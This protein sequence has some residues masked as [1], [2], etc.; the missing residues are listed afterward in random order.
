MHT[1]TWLAW[2]ITAL[3]LSGLTNNPSYLI[4][5]NLAATL[6][7]LNCR[8]STPLTRAY[9]L[10]FFAGF[11]IWIG[12]IVFSVITIGGARGRT[13]LTHLPTRTL[14]PLLGGITLG[15]PITL[16]DIIWGA[17]R[18]LRIWTILIIFGTF[19]AL[20]DHYR[21]LRL[22][23]RSLFHAGLAVTIA[24][25]FVPQT[26][27]AISE[28]TEAQRVRG[29]RL[30]NPRTWITLVAPLLASSLEKSIQ[31]AEALDSRGYGRTH[32]T[33]L[34]I[35]REQLGTI[36]GL[37]LL[38]G[39]LFGWLYY[40]TAATLISLILLITGILTI[41]TTLRTLGRLIPRTTYRPERWHHRDSLVLGAM[42]GCTTA[43]ITLVFLNASLRYNPYP[44]AT[45]P[46]FEPLAGIITLILVAP[47]LVGPA[48]PYLRI[49]TSTY[50]VRHPSFTTSSSIT[51][52]TKQT[53]QKAGSHNH[54]E[55]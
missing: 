35:G 24:I 4:L 6:V 51:H 33:D 34:Q 16:E 43:W 42:L 47:A 53:P 46:K 45:L 37:L 8:T 13:L 10:F 22:A 7:F 40:G 50:R 2:L 19:N 39:G 15:G 25:S 44:I 17:L 54:P 14:P 9:R 12:Y 23:P 48:R 27:R 31:L 41:A 1:A 32:T 18:G 5:I 26:I 20:I 36:L 11:I 52:R 28:I 21:L 55:R 3:L 49:K 29:Y 30:R 38:S